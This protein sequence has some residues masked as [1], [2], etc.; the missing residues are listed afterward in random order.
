MPP[1]QHMWSKISLSFEH[2]FELFFFSHIRDPLCTAFCDQ[3]SYEI[4]WLEVVQ[5]LVSITLNFDTQN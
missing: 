1:G 4:L 5:H 2:C 3:K